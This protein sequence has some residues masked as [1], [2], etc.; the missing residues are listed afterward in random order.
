MSISKE[1]SN[2]LFKQPVIRRDEPT[3]EAA[4][5][6]NEITNSNDSPEEQYNNFITE[7]D[8]FSSATQSLVKDYIKILNVLTARSA[9][10]DL[11]MPISIDDSVLINAVQSLYGAQLTEFTYGQYTDLLKLEKSIAAAEVSNAVL[12]DKL[13]SSLK[14][15][16]VPSNPVLHSTAIIK[17]RYRKFL[18][19]KGAEDFFVTDIIVDHIAQ[20]NSNYDAIQNL[21]NTIQSDDDEF[22]NKLKKLYE[23]CIPCDARILY[24]IERFKKIQPFKDFVNHYYGSLLASLST[25]IDLKTHLAGLHLM[26]NVCSII[27]GLMNFV[28]LPDLAGILSMLNFMQEKSRKL[29]IQYAYQL[30]LPAGSLNIFITGALDALL[31]IITNLVGTVFSAIDCIA[32]ALEAQLIKVNVSADTVDLTIS[33]TANNIQ[34]LQTE[35][36]N[37][38]RTGSRSI[39]SYVGGITSEIEKA[40][41]LSVTS[42]GEMISMLVELEQLGNWASLIYEMY[43]AGKNIGSIKSRAKLSEYFSKVK[44][45][46]C[47]AAY[48]TKPW[49]TY[50]DD[51]NDVLQ[52][53]L[54]SLYNDEEADTKSAQTAVVTNTVPGNLVK[55]VNVAVIVDVSIP[56]DFFDDDSVNILDNSVLQDIKDDVDYKISLEQGANIYQLDQKKIDTYKKTITKINKAKSIL[57][58]RVSVTNSTSQIT[59]HPKLFLDFKSCINAYGLEEYSQEQVEAWINKITSR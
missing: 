52:D 21:S 7:L 18:I 25:L 50:I 32:D 13:D 33:K 57:A 47:A 29:F 15:T 31:S 37:I 16:S 45:A 59:K 5:Y 14:D 43:E 4:T 19:D 36:V 17:D 6:I 39:K 24:S 23:D 44:T 3:V 55:S 41:Q 20:L 8:T 34:N 51:L 56:D 27:E 53:E 58:K 9:M 28:C 40:T 1:D 11:N 46:I 10:L 49:L 54:D 42:E 12:Q 22:K 38:M 30:S 48:S 26:S 2:K 35:F